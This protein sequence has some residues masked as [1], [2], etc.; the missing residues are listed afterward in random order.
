M[1]NTPFFETRMPN[2]LAEFLPAQAEWTGAVRLLDAS[3]L[4]DGGT[5]TLNANAIRQRTVCYRL[6]APPGGAP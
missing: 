3:R 6:P 5:L 1:L 4:P 2:R